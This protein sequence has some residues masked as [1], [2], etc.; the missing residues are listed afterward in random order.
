VVSAILGVTLFCV[1]VFAAHS[2][3]QMRGGVMRQLAE[4]G[5]LIDRLPRKQIGFYPTP[6]HRLGN[7]SHA[8]GVSIF[9]KREDM[10]GPG[11]IS[12]SKMR[13]AEFIIGQALK[14]GV[15]TIITQGV[16]LTN[17]GLQFVT[18]ARVAG[19]TPILYLTR[20]GRQG[21]ITEYRGNLLLNQI[22]DVE[23]HYLTTSG[24][25]YWN[26]TDEKNRIVNAMEAHKAK[27]QT[28]GHK[29]LIVPTGGAHHYGFVS[30][31]LT[32]KEMIEQARATGVELDYIYHTAGTGTALP[33][34]LVGKLFTGHKVKFRSIAINSYQ[35]G[36]WMNKN[37]IVDRVKHIFKVLGVEAVSDKDI[38]SEIDI[39]ERFIGEDYG[40]PTAESTAAIK[41]LARSDGVFIGPV[42]TGKGFAGLLEHVRSGRIEPGSNIAFLHTGDTGNLFETSGVVGNVTP[43]LTF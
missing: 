14:D 5:Q 29:V 18:A 2:G 37:V 32:F 33:G 6:F 39:D 22:M 27:L 7:L 20:D 35:P 3:D 11:A 28:E 25:A 10:A 21:P 9:M 1:Y 40:V 8:L 26:A 13:T 16:Y 41:E 38:Y 42:Y 34:M 23:T 15:D 30:H 4:L 17:S 24:G 31:A 36:G 19:I 43:P 12:G